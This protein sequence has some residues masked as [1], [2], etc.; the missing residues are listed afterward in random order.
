VLIDL[1]YTAVDVALESPIGNEFMQA[2]APIPTLGF[3]GRGYI[4]PSVSV[5]G[6]FSYFRVPESLGGEEF[7]GRYV[8]F[9]IYGTVNINDYVGAQVG[10]RTVHV[11]YFSELDTG[12]LK[13]KGLYFGGVVRF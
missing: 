2:P 1:K 3:V 7:G 10:Y 4:V 5:T 12:D 9:D 11:N 8:D 6:E 13:F